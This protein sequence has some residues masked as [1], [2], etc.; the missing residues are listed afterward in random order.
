[1]ALKL[2]TPKAGIALGSNGTVS[3]GNDGTP[4]VA[5]L[6]N[7]LL[8]TPKNVTMYVKVSAATLITLSVSPDGTVW[9]PAMIRNNGALATINFP[10]AG[11]QAID[12][13]PGSYVQIATSNACTVTAWAYIS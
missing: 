4:Q 1:M 13:T 11:A 6:G 2:I 10:G 3:S 5:G 9:Y 7:P 8:G 12:I